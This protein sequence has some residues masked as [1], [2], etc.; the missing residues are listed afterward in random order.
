MNQAES[1]LAIDYGTKRIG[2]AHAD[3]VRVPVPLNAAID[4]DENS[5]LD[6]IE[7]VIGEKRV[8]AIILGYPARPDGTAGEMA[9]VVEGFRDRL[10][11]RCPL[12]VHLVDER[13]SSQDA[14][15]HWNLKKARRKRKTGQL[16]SAAATLIL[17][18]YLDSL[19]PLP[20]ELLLDPDPDNCDHDFHA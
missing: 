13:L 7:K 8:K 4:G 1:W 16:D 5:R 17:R 6:Y 19:G 15:Q 20:S 9:K 10:T 3:E 2:L 12:P 18:E 11:E 14:G